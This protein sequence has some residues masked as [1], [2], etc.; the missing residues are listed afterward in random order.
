MSCLFFLVGFHPSGTDNL[1]FEGTTVI[2]VLIA[3]VCKVLKSHLAHIEFC[4]LRSFQ[5]PVAVSSYIND[6][7]P[8]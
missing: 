7:C 8:I 6:V 4:F 5:E 3:L 1:K 2:I